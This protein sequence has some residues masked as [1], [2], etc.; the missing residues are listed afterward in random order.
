MF[1]KVWFVKQALQYGRFWYP[2][3]PACFEEMPDYLEELNS[4]PPRVLEP[5]GWL[6]GEGILEFQKNQL[7]ENVPYI[8]GWYTCKSSGILYES[9]KRSSRVVLIAPRGS[10]LY[11]KYIIDLGGDY[12]G[13]TDFGWLMLANA[14]VVPGMQKLE[15]KKR[16]K[17]G[18]KVS[19]L[20]RQESL[21]KYE[22]MQQQADAFFAKVSNSFFYPC[23]FL[24]YDIYVA[25]P[26]YMFKIFNRS[27]SD[28][29]RGQICHQKLR[30]FL[31][32]I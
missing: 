9:A 12:M 16:K 13:Y 32:K 1:F 11:V 3:D 31:E 7:P 15:E 6:M 4:N 19:K 26:I 21:E 10:M 24:K 22:Q 27:L 2:T 29:I 18:P 25:I 20:S 17:R 28:C 8:K 14:L 30:E 5:E 23:L